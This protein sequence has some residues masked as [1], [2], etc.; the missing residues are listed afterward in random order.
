MLRKNITKKIFEKI[1]IL[2]SSYDLT[3]RDIGLIVNYIKKE[4][5]N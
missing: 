2:P 5:I 4:N 3:K 1:I